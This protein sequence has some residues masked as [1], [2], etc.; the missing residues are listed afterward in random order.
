MEVPLHQ[1]V[2]Q[3]RQRFYLSVQNSQ[4]ARQ[5]PRVLLKISSIM[6]ITSLLPYSIGGSQGKNTEVVC[7]SFLQWTQREFK[8]Y[9]AI[10]RLVSIHH[11]T[12]LVE[13]LIK[14]LKKRVP[15]LGGL[16]AEPFW[17]QLPLVLWDQFL[18]LCS[19]FLLV[20]PGY[21]VPLLYCVASLLTPWFF[22]FPI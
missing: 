18:L 8:C 17:G 22:H 5:K 1:I 9:T 12:S 10:K 21:I 2:Q 3:D 6:G 19:H 7:H 16:T 15:R 20:P 11:K 4:T 14:L 13:I